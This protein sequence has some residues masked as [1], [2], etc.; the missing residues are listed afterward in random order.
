MNDETLPAAVGARLEPGVG[1]LVPERDPARRACLGAVTADVRM[2]SEWAQ[3][4]LHCGIK[5]RDDMV[6]HPFFGFAA[7][8]CQE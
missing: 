1:R 5:V 3:E 7:S 2:G 6:E 8:G 4:C